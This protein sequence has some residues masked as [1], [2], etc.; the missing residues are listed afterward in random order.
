MPCNA[1]HLYLYHV[2]PG[3]IRFGQ[4]PNTRDVVVRKNQIEHLEQNSGVLQLGQEH[5]LQFYHERLSA[6]HAH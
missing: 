5:T 3:L 2:H 6:A 4:E 1:S